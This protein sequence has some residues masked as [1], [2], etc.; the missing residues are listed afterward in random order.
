VE[1]C[2]IAIIMPIIQASKSG[3][4]YEPQQFSLTH[5]I[6]KNSLNN[7]FTP[8]KAIPRMI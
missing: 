1:T 7:L 8:V 5:V 2:L 4:L 6:V 3:L